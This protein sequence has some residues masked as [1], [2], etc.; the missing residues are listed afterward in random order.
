[1]GVK[2][3]EGAQTVEIQYP[4][5]RMRLKADGDFQVGDKVRLSFPGNGEVV[6]AK[7]QAAAAGQG[8]LEGVSYTLPRNLDALKDLR[9]FEAQLV[10]WM[11]GR[12]R[13]TAPGGTPAAPA[14]SAFAGLTLPQLMLQAMDQEGGKEFLA[15]SLA[16]IDPEMASALLDSL[17]ASPGDPASKTAMSELLRPLTRPA[18]D[19]SAPAQAPA[20]RKTDA[21]LPAEAGE[22]HAPWFGRIAERRPADG[23]LL[24]ADRGS[25]ASPGSSGS[26][27]AAG[28]PGTAASGL[29]AAGTAAPTGA[30]GVRQPMFRYALDMGGNTL[31]AFSPQALE[32]GEFSDF[33]LERQAGRLQVRFSDPAQTLPA[34][35]RDALKAADPGMRQGMLLASRYLQEFKQEPYYGK[36]VQDFGAVL[37][38]SGL[39]AS[40]A[41]GQPAAIPKQEQMD[42]L[43]KLFVSFPR[44]KQDPVGQAKAWGD[45]VRDPRAFLKLMKDVKPNEES[46]L[47]RPETLLR[48]RAGTDP[49]A[50]S[51]TVGTLLAAA[52]E[53]G[54][55]P[56][57]SVAWLR[58][59]LPEAFRSADLLSLAKDPATT[60]GKEHEVAKFLLQAVASSL[61]QEAPIPEG[62]PTQ[63]FYY[64]GQE[65]RNLQVTWRR[66]D[67]GKDGR[68]RKGP[69]GP[70]QV[71]VETQA[72]HM[73]RVNVGVSWEPQ[74][75]RLDFK[76]Q[77]TDV[78]DLLTR[79]LPELEKSLALLDFKVSSW[80]YEMLPAD[81]PAL[82]SPG[83]VRPSGL[84]DLKG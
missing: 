29:P 49:A 31:E 36:L 15:Q 22:G 60:T 47:L 71:K 81:A 7:G 46:A 32:P 66:D 42:D 6:I 1:M 63:F 17:E 20:A 25:Y 83:S 40:P 78:R 41:P 10:N 50:A 56:E 74:G 73:G 3:E 13:P 58:K 38:Q 48:L 19:E 44:D 62:Q 39:L 37:S 64:Q 18:G 2:R 61:P 23:I 45:A 33:T 16:G 12:N 52:K 76:N 26:P 11:G 9:A 80:S 53:A 5:G 79:S 30:P 54:E 27:R 24:A 70:L 43:L 84:L 51:E 67:G 4:Q 65:W 75:A 14:P 57:A 34:G 28:T 77:F 8:D 55:S 82:S 59:L 68:G 21:F 72:K 35:L 69:K